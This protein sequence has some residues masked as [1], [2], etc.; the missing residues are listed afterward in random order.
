VWS[1]AAAAVVAGAVGHWFKVDGSGVV[2]K[3]YR[4]I[5]IS[6]CQMLAVLQYRSLQV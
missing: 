6:R 3:Q 5:P 1:A 2:E 4:G